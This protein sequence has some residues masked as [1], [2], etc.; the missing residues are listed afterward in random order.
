M[1][2]GG[3]GPVLVE[4]MTYRFVGHSRS[5]PGRYRPEGELERW[6]ARDPLV[7][8]AERLQSEYELTAEELEQ[9]AAEIDAQLETIEH[10]ALSAPFP[11]PSTRPEFAGAS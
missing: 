10:S 8:A 3:S 2:R 6:Q 9:V 7:I 5:D 1:T 11:E 4:A